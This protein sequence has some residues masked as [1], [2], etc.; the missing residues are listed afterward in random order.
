VLPEQ[1]TLADSRGVA[2]QLARPTRRFSGIG[3][4]VVVWAVSTVRPLPLMLIYLRELRVMIGQPPLVLP[5]VQTRVS[6]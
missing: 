4:T 2:E 5:R 1:I 6:E 3:V